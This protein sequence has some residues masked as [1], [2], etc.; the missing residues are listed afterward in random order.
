MLQTRIKSRGER[1]KKMGEKVIMGK[2]IT[3]V[4]SCLVVFAI[5]MSAVPV[6]TFALD[7][8]NNATEASNSSN[9]LEKSF[10]VNNSAEMMIPLFNNDTSGKYEVATWTEVNS[11]GDCAPIPEA[12]MLEIYLNDTIATVLPEVSN[13]T[14]KNVSAL[15]CNVYV[16]IDDDTC[17][18][19]EV[20]VD[21]VYKLTEGEG[22]TPDG[23]CAFYVSAGT[24]KFELRKN[25][26]STSKS[27]YCQCGTVYRWVSMPDYW[28][29]C[30]D[31]EGSREVKFRGTAQGDP[32][33]DSSV[34]SQ[35]VSV[36]EL[37]SGGEIPD[38]VVVVLLNRAP[39]GY[40]DSSIQHGDKVK[41]YGK[42]S[43]SG[44]DISLNGENYYIKKVEPSETLTLN[45]WTDKSEYKIGET[46]TIYYQTN[47]KCT[48]KL[49]I[50]KPDGGKVVYGPNEIPEC[51]RSKSPTAGYP[52]GKRTVV[53][54]AWAGDEYKKATCY[55]DV[56]EEA[57]EVKFRGKVLVNRPIISFY[58]IDTKIDE[59]LNDPTGKLRDGDVV[60]AWSHRDSPAKIEDPAVGDRVEVFGKYFGHDVRS[61]VESDY[62]DLETSAHYLKKRDE[63]KPD[64]M[65]ASITS[66]SPYIPKEGETV[67]FTVTTW[68]QGSGN[69][70]GFYVCCY[71]DGSYYD[72]DYISSLS[73]GSTTTTSFSWTAECGTHS[74]KAVADC[75][76]A[77]A[78]RNENNNDM[79]WTMDEI[80]CKP[81]LIV[82]DIDWEPANPKKGDKILFNTDIKNQGKGDAG[83]FYVYHYI[84]G[85]LVDKTYEP[86]LDA[87]YPDTV[88]F[89]GTADKCG[90]IQVKAVIDATGSV[91]ES[92]EENNERVE[93]VDVE[94]P[95]KEKP[96]LIIQ[97]ISWS[98]SNPKQGDTVTINVKTKN[99]GSEN[100]GGFYVGYY[101][102]GSYYARDYVSSL[103]AGST[104]T[105]SFSWTA[106]CGNHAIKAVA[107]CYNAVAESK[108]ENNWRS[109]GGLN[110]P[111]KPDLIIQ[112]ISLSPSNSKEGETVTFTVK[113]KNQGSENAGGFYVGYY[114]DGSYYDRDYVGSLSAG[115]TATT[116]FT[117]S[118][119]WTVDEYGCKCG[120]I[121]MKTVAD[122]Y[123]AVAESNETNNDYSYQSSITYC[124]PDLI[125][126][127]IS[128]DKNT[129][130]QGDTITFTVKV[131]NQGSGSAGSST[132][133]VKYY[134]NGSYVTSDSVPSLSAGSTS[135]QTFTWTANKCEN[136]QVKAVADA[137]NAID[138]SNEGNNQRIETVK[139]VCPMLQVP[140]EFQEETSWCGPASTA[141]VL[142]YYGKKV[143]MW[144]V[145]NTLNLKGKDGTNAGDI[146]NYIKRYSDLSIHEGNDDPNVDDG[147]HI[148]WYPYPTRASKLRDYLVSELT[149][150]KNPVI[151]CINKIDHDVVVVGVSSKDAL[152][153]TFYVNDPSGHLLEKIGVDIS[154]ITPIKYPV[155]W[156]QIE[157]FW[158]VM[159]GAFHT[160]SVQGNPNPP[161]GSLSNVDF[162]VHLPAYLPLANRSYNDGLKWNFSGSEYPVDD[163]SASFNS[164]DI[165]GIGA[166]IANH[167]DF[168][169]KYV[170][171]FT[172]ESGDV[173][174]S[175]EGETPVI[176][177][178][179]VNGKYLSAAVGVGGWGF[180]NGQNGIYMELYDS[181]SKLLDK[182]GPIRFNVVASVSPDLIIE[183]ISWSPSNPKE[184]DDVEFTIIVKNQGKGRADESWLGFRFFPPYI[185]V[186]SEVRLKCPPLDS[187]ETASLYDTINLSTCGKYTFKATADAR[188]DIK[189]SREDNNEKTAIIN[190][191]C[192]AKKP[193]LIIQDILWKPE[194]PKLKDDVEFTVT[195][196][197]Q[198]KGNAGKFYVDVQIN[199]PKS[200]DQF[201]RILKR[202]ISSLAAG[203]EY[204][205]TATYK[206]QDSGEYALS[207]FADPDFRIEETSKLNNWDIKRFEVSSEPE[208]KFI[209]TFEYSRSIWNGN[210][211]QYF[212]S[213]DKVLI[214][215]DVTCSRAS[216]VIPLNKP[217]KKLDAISSILKTLKKGD[218][219]LIHAEL[220][221]Q[222]AICD[223]GFTS[224]KYFVHRY[225]TELEEKY[226]QHLI[227]TGK[228]YNNYS[229]NVLTYVGWW[230][231]N[232]DAAKEG[233]KKTYNWGIVKIITGPITAY[234]SALSPM[235]GAAFRELGDFSDASFII[236]TLTGLTKTYTLKDITQ[237]VKDTDPK[238]L[239][240]DLKDLNSNADQLISAF[241]NG[242]KVSSILSDRREKLANV[243]ID[244]CA[245]DQIA[246]YYIKKQPTSIFTSKLEDYRMFHQHTSMLATTL[247]VDFIQTTAC[248][249]YYS[250]K[251]ELNYNLAQAAGRGFVIQR[252]DDG[253]ERAHFFGYFDKKGD[254][255]EYK[256]VMPKYFCNVYVVGDE[257]TFFYLKGSDGLIAAEGGTGKYQVLEIRDYKTEIKDPDT[258]VEYTLTVQC[259]KHAGPYEIQIQRCFYP[260]NSFNLYPKIEVLS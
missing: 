110:I 149:A 51:T 10:T 204:T 87:G 155:K 245:Y 168:T 40:F 56:V 132:S 111:C 153:P 184:G 130:K 247:A 93:T 18:G 209:G 122:C 73:A 113:T 125:I 162:D 137:T 50:T 95:P 142:K 27:W 246:F 108:E 186:G 256:L 208:I 180:D 66:N 63:K 241:E 216:I 89:Y 203:K 229:I 28:C 255:D 156:S 97:D 49:T 173:L 6:S 194:N 86:A 3:K 91:E 61:G 94:C 235:A 154:Q 36:D 147:E 167:M 114:V 119:T 44:C 19:Y 236:D 169:Q 187:G 172:T 152:D 64:L 112:D 201:E 30:D 67:T 55:F 39:K 248:E 148:Y 174:E 82:R 88:G 37:I 7:G 14:H 76:N 221:S 115:S 106:E 105:T 107:D 80:V 69:A 124:I 228:F 145:A 232:I 65:I 151:L 227:N 81:D 189:E 166:V 118:L 207:V 243:Y 150:D 146:F 26:C 117:T 123:N 38:Y 131:K 22:G 175:G 104:T 259:L 202:E 231:K 62:I 240:K 181:N 121:L 11:S 160:L 70:G 206:P 230:S 222:V 20:Y 179:E 144:D 210:A 195:V 250:G 90:D 199:T 176:A 171:K 9:D 237:M 52:T 140:Y 188:K 165:L 193:D 170:Y 238:I 198:G 102:D 143:H 215:K 79:V 59:I 17:V 57:K 158:T 211:Q 244:L 98:P 100:A 217:D 71:I 254:T 136:V 45:V 84:D 15:G 253:M 13:D 197:N 4:L 182:I 190:I 47:K 58:S 2:A 53:F 205:F 46:V 191:E 185:P 258:A 32:F 12:N 218:K 139:V 252:L 129:P 1:G 196:K 31:Q 212:F 214:G 226:P 141:M 220:K 23:Y 234:F 5:L 251:S 161:E 21:G 200:G 223:L 72:R 225:S 260:I 42:Y 16:K 164:T 183:D 249:K 68:N 128:W 133:T 48:A 29:E 157:Q 24:H 103:S 257:N 8:S 75:Y 138:E 74:I 192:P 120:S 134:I 85:E 178:K 83:G 43:G 60:T 219:I 233:M 177:P 126:Q 224:D 25:G 242:E 77:I 96:D 116:S 101:V 127:D 239:R 163:Y 92:N 54:E 34:T 109:K 135:T 159:G 35:D 33:G 99:Q 213:V 78:E 41:V